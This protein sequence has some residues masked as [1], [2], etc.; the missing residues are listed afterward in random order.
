MQNRSLISRPRRMVRTAWSGRD[1]LCFSRC[2]RLQASN[3]RM[4]HT[5][6]EWASQCRNCRGDHW[7]NRIEG[8]RRP[9]WA[10][11]YLLSLLALIIYQILIR[12]SRFILSGD[13]QGLKP[14]GQTVSL[15]YL[16]FVRSAPVR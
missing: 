13:C 7:G 5:V 3:W 11:S 8:P 12:K 6:Q 4:C 15:S 14:S 2:I 9:S 16:I 1:P 10:L